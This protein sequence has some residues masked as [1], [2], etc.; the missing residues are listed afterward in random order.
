[1]TRRRWWLLALA[2]AAL[3]WI[4]GAEW[5]SITHGIEENHF[6][7]AM[8]GLTFVGAGIVALDRRAGNVIGPLMIVFGTIA[9]I[10]NWSNL[11]L[12]V[13]PTLVLVANS[14]GAAFL[15]HIILAYPNGR[16]E[17]PFDRT[18]L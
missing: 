11:G 5:I 1:M 8:I 2:V 3:A 4:L 15:I 17:R 6:L 12:P 16:V 13:F 14:I 10:P 7:D 9:Y 18:V